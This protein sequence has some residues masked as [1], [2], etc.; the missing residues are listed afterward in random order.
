MPRRPSASTRA[1]TSPPPGGMKR[2]L[3]L[4]RTFAPAR[5]TSGNR[6][7]SRNGTA[8]PLRDACR[9]AR[10]CGSPSRPRPAGARW[11]A[12]HQRACAGAADVEHV[13]S[14]ATR[15]P[16]ERRGAC[17]RRSRL[18]R[19]P[20]RCTAVTHVK[21]AHE[22]WLLPAQVIFEGRT[23]C[24]SSSRVTVQKELATAFVG[25]AAD[26]EGLFAGP[27]A[28]DDD[29]VGHDPVAGECLGEVESATN[30]LGSEGSSVT[31]GPPCTSPFTHRT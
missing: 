31:T 24:R 15:A 23:A 22:A 16:D 27:L 9:R 4:E 30:D 25:A 10:R 21:L 14:P 2:A 12:T 20:R 26:D 13:L 3:Q 7:A 19:W 29:D 18:P 17:C 8:A 11:S 1:G 6:A 28:P 5:R